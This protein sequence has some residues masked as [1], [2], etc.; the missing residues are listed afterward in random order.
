MLCSRLP[1]FTSQWLR[2]WTRYKYPSHLHSRP[3][4]R[5]PHPPPSTLTHYSHYSLPLLSTSTL[6]LCSLPLLSASHTTTSLSA[7]TKKLQRKYVPPSTC[8]RCLSADHFPSASSLLRLDT[9]GEKEAASDTTT[10]T[11]YSSPQQAYLI[12][13][14]AQQSEAWDPVYW[15]SPSPTASSSSTLSNCYDID[16]THLGPLGWHT[17]SL[18]DRATF[19]VRPLVPFVHRYQESSVRHRSLCVPPQPHTNGSSTW[20]PSHSLRGVSWTQ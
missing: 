3:S 20:R 12:I 17:E 4:S 13:T 15:A 2:P 1:F 14:L 9:H 6:Y 5:S 19:D 16:H 10:G 18:Q 8:T 7:T 11:L